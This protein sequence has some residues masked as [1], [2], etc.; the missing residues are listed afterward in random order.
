MRAAVAYVGHQDAVKP[1]LTVAENLR[2]WGRAATWQRHWR[3]SD[4]RP[5]ANCRPAC[6]RPASAAGSPGAAGDAA[7]PTYGCWTSRPWGS[8]RPRSASSRRC[9]PGIGRKAA[10]SSQR[11]IC[12]CRC[13]APRTLSCREAVRGV[14]RARAAPVAPPRR[15]HAWRRC[16]SS[17]SPRRCSRW[18]SGR[19]RR[20]LGRLAPGIIWVCALLAALL[21]LDRLFGADFEDGSLD[22][23]L[24][25]GLP[26]AGHRRGEG[27][28][29]IG[30]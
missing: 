30:W 18:R 26:A 28:R 15:R 9:W 25:C 10:S 5:W 11:P 14:A 20:R 29:R 24:L 21:P 1:G 22:Q 4:W 6:C 13:P 19:R 3:R 23:L 8:T 12:R 27:V 7:R 16:C 17:C 2:V